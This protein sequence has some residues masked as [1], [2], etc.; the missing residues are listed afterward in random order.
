MNVTPL[1]LQV[2]FTKAVDVAANLGKENALHEAAQF[3]QNEDQT[4]DSRNANEVVKGNDNLDE[5]F[6]NV[7]EDGHTKQ[8]FEENNNPHHRKQKNSAIKHQ[9]ATLTEDGTGNLIDI[10]D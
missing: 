4:K 8:E 9:K 1:D 6:S 3:V 10:L 5:E 7:D 2:L